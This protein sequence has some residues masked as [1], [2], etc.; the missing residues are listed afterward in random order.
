[1]IDVLNVVISAASTISSFL[2]LGNEPARQC[3]AI[4]TEP[5]GHDKPN[6]PHA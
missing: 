1:M 4:L 3:L 5:S 6:D 2:T